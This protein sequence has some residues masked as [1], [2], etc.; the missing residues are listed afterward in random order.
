[1]LVP[2]SARGKLLSA[3]LGF[4]RRRLVGHAAGQ[5]TQDQSPQDL[6][7]HTHVIILPAREALSAILEITD[8]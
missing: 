7:Q 2:E 6:R 4:E 8:G 5:H 3:A 1:M